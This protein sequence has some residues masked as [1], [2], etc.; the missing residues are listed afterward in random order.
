MSK[1]L[2]VGAYVL[3]KDPGCRDSVTGEQIMKPCEYY[4]VIRGYD[5]GRTKY[6]V[7]VRFPGWG[8]WLFTKG[9]SWTFP[10]WCTEVTEEEV[11]HIPERPKEQA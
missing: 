1:L 11:N 2:P 4:A 8:R 7:G 3:V 6:E 9:G 10:A 5:M